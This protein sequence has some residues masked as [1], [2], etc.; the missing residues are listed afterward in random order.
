M[1]TCAR[2]PLRG[3]PP[4]HTW[5]MRPLPAALEPLD[6]ER[7][8]ELFRE[9]LLD[10]TMEGYFKLA[11]QL[12]TQADPAF[13]GLASLV[14]ALNALKIDPLRPW[15]GAWRWFSE[16]LMDC[17]KSLD[18]VRRLGLS[19]DEVACLARCSEAS[20]NVYRPPLATVRLLREH[21]VD[22]CAAPD[23]PI[24]IA[25]YSRKAVGQTGSGHFSPLAGYHAGTDSVLVLDTARFKYPPHWMPVELL[26]AAMEAQDPDT[27]R[28]RGWM[29]VKRGRASVPGQANGDGISTSSPRIITDG[30]RPNIC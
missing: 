10:G 30:A 9:A 25:N 24:L 26:F 5:Y 4:E 20:V 21:I 19:L 27:G 15:K 7:G 1:S 28:A 3:A 8:R 2:S 12:H 23:A 17:C 14:C 11:Q 18:E 16:E 22:A 6:S 13:C 29:S